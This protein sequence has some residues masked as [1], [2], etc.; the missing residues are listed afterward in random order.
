[1]SNS[2]KVVIEDVGPKQS[3]FNLEEATRKNSDYR[4]VAWSG[5]YL[6]VTLMSIKPGDSI[7]LEAH[8]QNDQFLR[9]DQGKGKC[10]MGPS[11][12]NL[13]FEQE[14]TDGWGICVPAGIWHDVINTGDEDMRLY[15]IYAPVH[16]APGII[17]ATA[18]EAEK[19]EDQGRDEP[20]SWSVQPDEQVED[21]K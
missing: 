7:G 5:K 1:M 14:V 4:Q 2:D 12:D 17:Q 19:D 8:P 16:H 15:A 3:V 20:P 6:Q 21:K 13:N 18:D 10:V 11:K 9:L